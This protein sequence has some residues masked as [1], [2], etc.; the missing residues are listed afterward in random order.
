MKCGI[1]KVVFVT[2]S[3]PKTLSHPLSLN[4]KSRL[5]NPRG[6]SVFYPSLKVRVKVI[7]VDMKSDT[8]NMV[9]VAISPM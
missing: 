3:P 1:K 7:S 2:I 5:V 6:I 4:P 9:F 8:I